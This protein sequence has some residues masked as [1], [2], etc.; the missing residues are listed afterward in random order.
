MPSLQIEE[1]TTCAGLEALGPAWH[2]LWRRAPGATPFHSPL[3]LIPWWREIGGG[4]LRVLV[5]R[6]DVRMVGLLPM[7]LQHDGEGGKLLPLG[8]AISDYLDGL[9]E[10]GMGVIAAEAMLRHLAERDDWRRCELHPLRAGSPLLEAHAPPCCTDEVLDFEPCVVVAIPADARNLRD[11][12]PSRIRGKL[13][14]FGRRAEQ[15]GR[16]R[17]ETATAA[18]LSEF[19]EALFRLHEARWRRLDGLGV[20]ADPVVRDFHRAAAPLLLSA[21]LLRLHALRLDERIVA[22][23]Y[24]LFARGRVYSYLSGFD[25]ELGTISPGTLALGHAIRHTIDEGAREFDFLRG[26]ERF[27]YFWGGRDRPCYGRMLSRAS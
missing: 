9:F 25:P 1:V 27:K 2:D 10:E 7:Y 20:L 14:Y 12:V 26:Q 23:V 3:W 15:A 4:E 18:T 21:G 17:F 5:A 6:Q 19:L 22:V 24:A 8:I 11:V 13:R 16:V